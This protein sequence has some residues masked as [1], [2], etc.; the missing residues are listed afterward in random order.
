MRA[1]AASRAIVY[2]CTARG[3][4]ACVPAGAVARR[5]GPE[6]VLTQAPDC[7]A[8]GAASVASASRNAG[9]TVARARH[10]GLGAARWAIVQICTAG[11]SRVAI[12]C[13]VSGAPARSSLSLVIRAFAALSRAAASAPASSR[14]RMQLKGGIRKWRRRHVEARAITVRRSS[15]VGGLAVTRTVVRIFA[16]TA[17][18]CVTGIAAAGSSSCVVIRTRAALSC[19][20]TLGT[21]TS[22]RV[23]L[24]TVAECVQGYVRAPTV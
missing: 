13:E 1:G 22:Y 3:A 24:G 7:R 18:A 20:A 4:I 2:I 23:H 21:I 12:A 17:A 11:P 8:A 16:R 10:V 15:H 5:S 6:V 14:R 9:V 19:A